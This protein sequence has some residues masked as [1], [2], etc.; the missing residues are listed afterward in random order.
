MA[1]RQ[2]LALKVEGSIPS[3]PANIM[4]LNT[5]KQVAEAVDTA[6]LEKQACREILDYSIEIIPD[7]RTINIYE[8]LNRPVKKIK[9][10][11]KLGPHETN[12][13]R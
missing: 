8:I 7:D 1:E 3:T 9:A 13:S 6:L 4:S 11:I 2:V 12:N 5:L 10:T